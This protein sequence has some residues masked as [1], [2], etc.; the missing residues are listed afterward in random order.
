MFWMKKVPAG[1][2]SWIHSNSI[3]L[4]S[5][6]C[7]IYVSVNWVSIASDNGLSPSQCQA[8]I[9]TN[10]G[11]LSIGPLWTNFNEISIKIHIFTFKKIHLKMSSWKWQ[12]FCLSLN[13]LTSVEG[14]L[15]VSY[16]QAK[17]FHVSQYHCIDMRGGSDGCWSPKSPLSIIE[18]IW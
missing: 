12:P 16:I 15:E 17:T 3:S 2:L 1:Q 10:A 6:L 8:I 11:I 7:H 18:S 14:T 5:P 13:V 9:W 4:I